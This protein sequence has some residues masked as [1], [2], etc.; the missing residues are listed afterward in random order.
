[1]LGHTAAQ[2]DAACDDHLARGTADP[3]G[4]PASIS[5]AAKRPMKLLQDSSRRTTRELITITSIVLTFAALVG[6]AIDTTAPVEVANLLLPTLAAVAVFAVFSAVLKWQV[7]GNLFGELGFLYLG[8]AVAYTVLPASGFIQGDVKPGDPLALL[9]PTSSELGTHL[10]RHVLFVF[11]VAAGYLLARGRRTSQLITIKDPRGKDG[12]TIVFLIGTISICILCIVFMSA[13]VQSYVDHYTRYDHLPW[14]SRKFVS[15]C[16]RMSFGFYTLL[17]VFLFLN[18]KKYKLLI[19]IVVAVICAHE[20]LYSLGA[21]IQALIILLATLCL[22]NY[23][24]RSISLKKGLMACV[25]LAALFSA[26][27]LFRESGFDL[28]LARDVV[29]ER[30]FR[31]GSEFGSVYYPGFHLYEERAMGGLPPT[32]WPMFFNDFISTITFGDFTRW[33]PMAWY[34]RNYYPRSVVAP[35][36]LGPIA[37]SAIWGGEVDLLLRSLING[38]WFAFLVRWFVRHKHRW[39]GVT[40]YVYC[41]ATCILALKYSVFYHLTPLL[42]TVLP[43]LLIVAVVRKLAPSRRKSGLPS[44]ARVGRRDDGRSL[45]GLRVTPERNRSRECW[46]MILTAYYGRMNRRL[47]GRLWQPRMPGNAACLD[48]RR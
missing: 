36:T 6:A 47:C 45:G 39:W 30:G 7:G 9:S 8:L 42:K 16:L 43:T 44:P 31:F 35:F 24:V 4:Q 20:T 48:R 26:I 10:W 22:Y 38:A 46:S 21:R 15:V 18:Y 25:A 23:T 17:L 11:G 41:Y 12:P 27:E 32:E 40:I 28:S 34:A 2:W 19:P 37:D 14:L 3:S 1:V 33:N 29:S 5:D 13:P